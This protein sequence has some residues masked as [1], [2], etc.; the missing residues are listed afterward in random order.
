MVM[1]SALT[2]TNITDTAASAWTDR[3]A[4]SNASGNN[5]HTESGNTHCLISLRVIAVHVYP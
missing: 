1:G 3:W 2:P 5:A 4:H